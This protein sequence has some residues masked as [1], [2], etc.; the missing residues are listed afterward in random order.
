MTQRITIAI[1]VFLTCVGATFAQPPDDAPSTPLESGPLAAQMVLPTGWSLPSP[2]RRLW[3]STDYQ[4]AFMRSSLLPPLVTTSDTGTPRINAGV[5]GKQGTSILLGDQWVNG[6]LRS[7]LRLQAGYWFNPER[8][9]GVEAGFMV[10]EGQAFHFAASSDAFPILGRPFTDA[11][12]GLPSSQLIAFPGSTIG[13][14]EARANSSNF[15]EAHVDVTE[16]A[17]D[18]GWF[19]L[20]SIFGYRY[21]RLDDG[22]HIGQSISPTA[23]G[24][25]PGTQIVNNDNFNTRNE[26]HGLDL[27]FRS[28][29]NWNTLSLELLTKLAVGRIIRSTNV[30]G[31]QTV[32]VPGTAP[33]VQSGGLLALSTNSGILGTADWKVMPEAGVTLSWQIRPN[34]SL[35]L[36]YSF[37]FLN[38]VVRAAD[39]IDTTLNPHFFA[40][41]NTALGGPLRPGLNLIRS[42]MWIQSVNL[43]VEL[44]Y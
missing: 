22:V 21:Y 16:K 10:L 36:G 25:V 43:G 14:V 15:Y 2:D 34:L 9:F 39:Q 33:V 7:G 28:Q 31:D 1:G 27:G 44:T 41:A 35:N 19:R 37:L 20:T 3:V 17:L 18:E 30:N 12:T 5:L 38:G 40:G 29:F 23:V 8:T 26:F 13:T 6:G 11:N 42:D 4:F 32:T 24:F